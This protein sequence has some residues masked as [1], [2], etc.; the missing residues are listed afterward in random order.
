LVFSGP[1]VRVSVVWEGYSDEGVAQS[2]LKTCGLVPGRFFGG[3]GKEYLLSRLANYNSAAVRQPWFALVDLDREPCVAEASKKWLPA[4]AR[5]MRLAI[6]VVEVEAWLLAD[7]ESISSFLGVTASRIPPAPEELTD[8]K[9]SLVS[10]ARRSRRRDIRAGLVPRE[11]S[12][13]SVGPTYSSDMRNFAVTDW[14]P[15]VAASRAPSLQRCLDRLEDLARLLNS[16]SAAP[17]PLGPGS[18]VGPAGGK[19]STVRQRRPR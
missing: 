16:G 6:A 5:Y 9:A 4:P 15:K 10:L 12:K 3:R 19:P 11:G 7:V 1:E 13:A 17:A 2:L 14:R 8:P 18:D